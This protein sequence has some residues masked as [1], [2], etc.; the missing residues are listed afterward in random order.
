MVTLKI[1]SQHSLLDLERFISEIERAEPGEQIF[2]DLPRNHNLGFFKEARLVALLVTAAQRGKLVIRDAHYVWKPEETIAYFRSSL[3]ALAAISYAGQIGNAR[4]EDCPLQLA[5]LW[6]AINANGGVLEPHAVVTATQK[7]ELVG[8]SVTFCALDPDFS[9]PGL[10]AGFVDNKDPFIKWFIGLRLVKDFLG[11]LPPPT[12][13]DDQ[14][15]SQWRFAEYIYEIYS[16]TLEHGNRGTDGLASIPGLRYINLQKY[17]APTADKAKEFAKGVL[18]LELY[19]AA[20]EA[21]GIKNR[22]F[23]EVSIGDQG[24]GVLEHFMNARPEY[25]K[26][27]RR[28]EDRFFLLRRLLRETLS[29]KRQRKGAGEGLQNALKACR[30]LRAFVTFRTDH[31]WLYAS[32][33]QGEA[34]PIATEDWHQVEHDGAFASV[35]GTH[36]SVL[37]PLDVPLKPI[38]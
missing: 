5:E 12:D 20:L 34:T 17:Y 27:L 11:K 16:N 38:R 9:E 23:C 28:E 3:P 24:L 1:K 22:L 6:E 13:P 21:N 18:S 33:P 37:I 7:V 10:L 32:F 2:V 35:A 36:F 30:R 4:K 26:P 15:S 19:L 29:S 8:S 31:Y 14:V 25:R